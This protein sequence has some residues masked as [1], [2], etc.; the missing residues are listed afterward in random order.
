V[1]SPPQAAAGWSRPGRPAG[2]GVVGAGGDLQHILHPPAAFGVMARGMHQRWISHA[3]AGLLYGLPHRL[4]RDRLHHLELHHP[5]GQQPQRPALATLR[6]RAARQHDQAGLLL[7]IQPTAVL[8][9]GRLAVQRRLQAGGDVLPADA[10]DGGGLTSTATAIAAS[11]QP[12]PA[13]PWLALSRMRAWAST[14][15]GATPRP[16]MVC[17]RARS[18]SDRTTMRRLRTSASCARRYPSTAP[19]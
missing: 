11:V 5:L 15:A 19:A 12:G 9:R 3:S 18:S 10:G 1:G 7:P 16:I 2:G 4:I 17:S 13:W 8:A 6:R 14:L